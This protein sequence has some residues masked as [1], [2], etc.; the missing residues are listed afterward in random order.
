MEGTRDVLVQ[1]IASL[2]IDSYIQVAKSRLIRANVE[3]SEQHIRFASAVSSINQTEMIG[4]LRD[5]D[6]HLIAIAKS[7]MDQQ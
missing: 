1:L 4:F 2:C 7:T 5:L 3:Q 6:M